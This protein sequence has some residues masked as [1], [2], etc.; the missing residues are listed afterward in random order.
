[1][2]V[3]AIDLRGVTLVRRTQE[4][5]HYDLKRTVLELFSGRARRVH[6]HTVLADVSLSVGHGEKVALIGP[7]GSGKSTMLKVIAGVLEPTRGTA[8]V[9]GTLSPLI[10]LGAGFDPELSLVDNI[11]YYGVLLGHDEATVRASVD[12]IL[13]FAEL[14]PLRDHPTK[15]LSSGMQARLAF[16]IAT[17]FRPDVLL[18]DEVLAVGD[19]R[20]VR[21]SAVRLDRFWDAHSTIVVVSHN[22]SYITRTCN[23]AI[24]LDHGSI[25]FDGPAIEAVQRYLNTVPGAN[26]FRRG[27][28]LIALARESERGEIVVRGTSPTDQGM[29][30]FLIRDG[31]RHWITTP[32]W[33]ARSGYIWEDII[34][35]D[36]AVILEVPE[37]DRLG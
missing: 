30:V 29:K 34:H 37:G 10:E 20:F 19:E 31:V 26:A 22:L 23:R 8:A 17:E 32:E 16:A 33:Y 27:E 4:E 15:T 9:D 7:N 25:R 1:V 12:D 6:R 35:V 36:D 3:A 5:L 13:D 14:R 18:L 21:K 2:S 28:E 24:W 11:V